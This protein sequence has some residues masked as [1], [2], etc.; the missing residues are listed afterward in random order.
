MDRFLSSRYLI[1]NKVCEKITDFVLSGSTGR[2][3]GHVDVNTRH[4]RKT[5]IEKDGIFLTLFETTSITVVGK[6][7]SKSRPSES[8]KKQPPPMFQPL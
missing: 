4:I 7:T 2:V 6:R 1:L 8:D 3:D 5:P